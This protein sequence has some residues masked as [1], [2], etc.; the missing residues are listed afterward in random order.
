[1]KDTFLVRVNKANKD[2][3]LNVQECP[4]HVKEYLMDYGIKQALNDRLSQVKLE[5][6]LADNVG[7]SEKDFFLHCA[8]KTTAT[9]EAFKT[10]DI[11]VGGGGGA[12][13]SDMTR[14]LR[15]IVGSQLGKLNINLPQKLTMIISLDATRPFAE[16]L[17]KHHFTGRKVTDVNIQ[18]GIDDTMQTWEKAAQARI[19][20]VDIEVDVTSWA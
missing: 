1:M 11:R 15:T 13:L 3:S 2:F 4:L 17:V 12:R 5:D 8:K 14:E 7:S 9:L 6:F 20:A 10:G 16:A 18:Y 19:D